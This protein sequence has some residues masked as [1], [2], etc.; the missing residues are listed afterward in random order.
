MSTQLQMPMQIQRPRAMRQPMF[1]LTLAAVLGTGC[2]EEPSAAGGAAEASEHAPVDTFTFSPEAAQIADLE[3]DT[4]RVMAWQASVS[5][6]GR[7]MLDPAALETLGS[8]TEGRITSVT[9]RVGDRVTAGQTLVMIHSHEIMEARSGL[10]RARAQLDA[11][12]AERDL[13]KTSAERAQRLFEARAMSRAELEQAQVAQRVARARFDEATAER[14]RAVALVDHLV[15]SD[16]LPKGADEHDVLIRTPISGV[17]TERVAQPGTVVLPGMPLIT[18]G[19]PRRLQLQLHLTE[20]AAAGVEA[21]SRVRYAFTESPTVLY[22][23][24]VVRVAPTVDTLT[25]TIEVI[26]RPE[27]ATAGRA[28]SFVQALVLGKGSGQKV[29]VVPAGAVQAIDADTVVFVVESRGNDFW[30]RATP[31]RVGRRS[32]EHVELL[33]GVTNGTAVVVRGAAIAKAELL[34]RRGGGGAEH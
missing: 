3:V 32:A 26:A 24:S 19:D 16:P 23:A 28:E 8:I 33:A 12:V 17:V 31:V 20:G 34:R 11:A 18:V 5:V 27:G 15:G 2:G 13:A 4:A 10:Q 25:R 14:D 22:S 9:V 30:L 6:P 29:I 21:G 1:I 7:L